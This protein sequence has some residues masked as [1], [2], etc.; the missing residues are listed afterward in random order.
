MHTYD[1]INTVN[2]DNDNLRKKTTRSC[3][4]TSS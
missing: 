4:V 3:P 1:T 2:N